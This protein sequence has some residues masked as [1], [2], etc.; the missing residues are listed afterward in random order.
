MILARLATDCRFVYCNIVSLCTIRL[1]R[2]NKTKNFYNQHRTVKTP[3]HQQGSLMALMSSNEADVLQ[4]VAYMNI[5]KTALASG[6]S[7]PCSFVSTRI[8]LFR[9]LQ[10]SACLAVVFLK[11]LAIKTTRCET[12]NRQPDDIYREIE[13]LKSAVRELTQ[14]VMM[15]QMF[16]EERSVC[17]LYFKYC[18]CLMSSFNI[19]LDMNILILAQ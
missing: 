7:R 1:G 9:Y 17:E 14:Q 10:I 13:A 12:A 15:Q 5:I 8:Y 16:V 6:I 19:T 11:L 4:T 3:W 2:E 18:Y